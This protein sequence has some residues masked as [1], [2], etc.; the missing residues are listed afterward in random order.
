MN[1]INIIDILTFM[2]GRKFIII[3]IDIF[4]EIIMNYRYFY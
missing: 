2:R 1:K 3:Y 4:T